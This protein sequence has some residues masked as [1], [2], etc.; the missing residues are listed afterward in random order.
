[1][2]WK[3]EAGPRVA[4]GGRVSR[5]LVGAIRP[6]AAAVILNE[7]RILVWDDHNPATREVVSV[8][9]AGGIEFGETGAEAIVRELHEEIGAV[10]TRAE[11][12]GIIEDIF[13]WDSQTRHELYLLYEVELGDRSVYEM[14]EVSV[15]E[16]DGT[17]YVAR[18]RRLSEFR[19]N[20]RLVPDG[21]L[22][23]LD[24]LRRSNEQ[25]N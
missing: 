21:L 8:P 1:M 6:L 18:W 3:P 22:E 17:D 24:D 10:V 9:L 13:E 4:K 15:V 12:L 20:A 2:K 5:G 11:Y 16:P 25:G 19:A 7:D 14:D 23:L